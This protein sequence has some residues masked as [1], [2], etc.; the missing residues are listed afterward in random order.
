MD[1]LNVLEKLA[2][3]ISS[4]L[5]AIVA[6]ALVLLIVV[7]KNL[8]PDSDRQLKRKILLY[9]YVLNGSVILICLVLYAF[10]ASKG[11][12]PPSPEFCDV[13]LVVPAD[14]RKG[15]VFLNDKESKSDPTSEGFKIQVRKNALVTLKA[16]G[17]S[18][19]FS[20]EVSLTASNDT[21]IRLRK[22]EPPPPP[23]FCKVTLLVPVDLENGTVYVNGSERGSEPGLGSLTIQ[24]VKNKAVALQVR[25]DGYKPSRK[26]TVQVKR[27]TTIDLRM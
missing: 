2:E 26:V 25:N 7:A 6:I 4:E 22:I 17:E 10:K 1:S 27:D 16:K 21:T 13:T 12:S 20:E 23:G 5:L 24:V 9:T 15:T 3:H 18:G 8:I 19:L 11:N 14:L